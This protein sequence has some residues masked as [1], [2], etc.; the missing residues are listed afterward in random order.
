MKN[1]ENSAP[2]ETDEVSP[3]PHTSAELQKIREDFGPGA[4]IA[5]KSIY[6]N[7]GYKVTSHRGHNPTEPDEVPISW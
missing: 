7:I 6:K 3:G 1:P 4:D 2:T 5:L